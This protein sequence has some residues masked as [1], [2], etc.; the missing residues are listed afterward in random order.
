MTKFRY[1]LIEEGEC[2]PQRKLLQDNLGTLVV[3]EMDATMK[4]GELIE[5]LGNI[6]K[7]STPKEKP[8]LLTIMLD[9]GY[10]DLLNSQS[11][12]GILSSNFPASSVAFLL[13]LIWI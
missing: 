10:V 9:A 7:E 6:W 12:V 5:N 4:A 11:I 2:N 13:I 3:L 1:G 8:K